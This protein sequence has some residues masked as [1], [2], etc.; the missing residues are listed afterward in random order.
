MSRSRP[1]VIAA[2]GVVVLALTVLP[3]RAATPADIVREADAAFARED[4]KKAKALYGEASRL[5]PDNV[6][7]VHRLALLQS[8]DGELQA[9]VEN[10]RRALALMPDDLEIQLGLARVLSL[11]QDFEES[12]ALYTRL[13]EKHPDNAR[14]LLGLGDTLSLA[15]RHARADEVFKDMEDRRIE[16]IQAH[17]GRARLRARQGKYDE[18]ERF[19]RDVLRADP[20]NLDARIGIAYAHHGQGLDRSAREQAENIVLD[21]PESREARELEGTIRKGLRPHGDAD[22]SR[23]SDADTNRVDGATA[24]YTFMAE[25]QTSIRIAYSTYDAEFRCEQAQ[26]CDE[27]GVAVGDTIDARAQ[28]LTG[29]LT[30]RVISP[31]TFNARLGAVREESFG[32]RPRVVGILGGY[33]RWQVGPRFALGTNGGRDVFLDSAALIDRGIRSTDANFR[34]ELRFKPAWLLS[35]SAG[36]AAFSDGNG[37]R[38]AGAAIEWRLPTEHPHVTGTVDARYRTF[39]ADLDNGYFDP[40]RYDS[41]LLTVAAWDDYRDGSLHWRLEGTYGRQAYTVGAV[42]RTDAVSGGAALAGVD[43]ARGRAAFEASY[44]RS[45]YALN[46]AQGLTYSRTGFTLR[47]R[48]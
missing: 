20:G 5:D 23:Y 1:L 34:L 3:A 38:A 44:A 45:N 39:N 35:G 21:H 12:I 42:T 31:L 27:P 48:F 4:F 43:F 33:V 22:T 29:A 15:G 13:R 10:Y 14:V 40:R 9:S 46:V 24:S 47:L 30:S 41:E 6:R 11:T 28:V 36:A 25:P 26:L 16:A 18:A 37:R 19:W 2:V 17:I 32:G 8:W 7:A